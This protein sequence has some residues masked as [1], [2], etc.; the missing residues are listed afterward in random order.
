[1]KTNEFKVFAELQVFIDAFRTQRSTDLEIFFS[2]WRANQ[3]Y[4]SLKETSPSLPARGLFTFFVFIKFT[5]LAVTYNVF[6]G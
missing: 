1:M 2:C 6:Y 4:C 5:L 3:Y